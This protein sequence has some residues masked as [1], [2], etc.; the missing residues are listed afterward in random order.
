MP[1]PEFV[2][3]R[4]KVRRGA[5]QRDNSVTRMASISRRWARVMTFRRSA[6]TSLPDPVDSRRLTA[7]QLQMARSAVPRPPP[8]PKLRREQDGKFGWA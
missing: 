1:R 3:R 6:K 7:I 2:Q 5:A 8:R 4:Q